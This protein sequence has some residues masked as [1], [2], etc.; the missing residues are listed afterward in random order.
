MEL[1]KNRGRQ[2]KTFAMKT[3]QAHALVAILLLSVV[4]CARVGLLNGGIW[5]ANCS[6]CSIESN[7][8]ALVETYTKVSYN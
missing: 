2:G 3:V 8:P 1:G 4:S 6:I 7:G 5:Q